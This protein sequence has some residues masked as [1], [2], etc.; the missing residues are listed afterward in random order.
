[1]I[2]GR[3]IFKYLPTM[4]WLRSPALAGLRLLMPLLGVL[5]RAYMLVPCCPVAVPLHVALQACLASFIV[6]LC[7]VSYRGVRGSGGNGELL[8]RHGR[9]AGRRAPLGRAPSPLL[10]SCLGSCRL[11]LVRRARVLRLQLRAQCAAPHKPPGSSPA[12]L[13]CSPASCLQLLTPPALAL[14]LPSPA[15]SSADALSSK[16]SCD[17]TQSFDSSAPSARRWV[18]FCWKRRVSTT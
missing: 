15:F 12:L 8:R 10:V 5:P 6:P 13:L 17:S 16:W 2:W 3:A 1:M 7:C 9:R 4:R 18:R 11:W 14:S